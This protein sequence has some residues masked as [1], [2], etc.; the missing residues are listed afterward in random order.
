MLSLELKVA[1]LIFSINFNTRPRAP[2]QIGN[3]NMSFIKTRKLLPPSCPRTWNHSRIFQFILVLMTL[4]VASAEDRC[5]YLRCL[6]SSWLVGTCNSCNAGDYLDTNG[7]NEC[8][9]CEPG[10]Y[11]GDDANYCTSCGAGKYGN[12]AQADEYKSTDCAN[13]AA[14]KYSTTT[15]ATSSSTCLACG[16]GRYSTTTGATSSST[17]TA[18]GAG[19][20]SGAG[21]SSCTAC[22]AGRY[23]G[24]VSSSCTACGAGKYST[25]TGATSYLT[26]T[27]CGAGKFSTLTGATTSSTCTACGA[28]LY[29]YIGASSCSVCEAGK[30]SSTTGATSSSFCT[31]CGIG[32]YSSSTS[33]TAC[34]SCPD[35][36]STSSTGSN[37]DSQC[38]VPVVGMFLN[39]G[40]SGR[41]AVAGNC[42]SNNLAGSEYGNNE[43]CTFLLGHISGTLVFEHFNTESG[44]DKLTIGGTDYSGTTAINAFGA[45]NSAVTWTSDG[46]NTRSGFRACVHPACDIGSGPT[47]DSCQ[48]CEGE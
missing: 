16:A 27:A 29:S 37:S 25:T 17:C 44:R 3:L 1:T 22:G 2:S 24:A 41:C 30:Y 8:C 47:G 43:A 12:S 45:E 13:C 18:C 38:T 34:T 7:I 46:S 23:S 5:D 9:W 15:G 36:Y 26:C 42:F 21:S 48:E 6:T 40:A 10:K 19:R 14:G 31:S 11:S 4:S 35:T 32:E 39:A 20:Y 33:S 28:G